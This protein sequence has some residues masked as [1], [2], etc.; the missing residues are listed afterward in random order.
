MTLYEASQKL[1]GA[2]AL[3][4]FLSR[5]SRRLVRGLLIFAVVVSALYGTL[6]GIFALPYTPMGTGLTFIFGAILGSFWLFEA[7]YNTYYFHGLNSLIGLEDRKV[8]GCSYEVA[9]IVLSDASDIAAAFLRSPVG[10]EAALRSGLTPTDIEAFIGDVRTPTASAA[11]TIPDTLIVRLE[12]LGLFLLQRD[13]AFENFIQSKGIQNEQFMGALRWVEGRMLAIKRRQRWWGKDNLSRTQ[14][15]GRE[16]AFGQTFHLDQFSKDI[17]SSTV[18]TTVTNNTAY[19]TE[20]VQEIESILARELS[21]NVLLVGEAG[22]GKMDLLMEVSRR[23]S[24][25][26]AL[27]AITGQR[28][29]VLD[30]ER[31]FTV[32]AEKD[33]I[34]GAILGLLTEA[35]EAGNTII[36]I[37]NISSFLN[38]TRAIN[39]NV[40][41]I[42]DRFLASEEVHI[43]VTDTPNNYH[44]HLEPLHGFTR[45][46]QEV[47]VDTPSVE[48]TVRVLAP[49]AEMHEAE[50]GPLFTYQSLVALATAADRYIVNGVMPDKAVQ[51]LADVNSHCMK[52]GMPFVTR[53]IVYQVVSEQTGIP[54]GPIQES[55]KELLLNLEDILHQKVVGQHQAIVAIAK[56]MRRARAGIQASDRPIGSFLF[57]G[58][59]G[60]GKTETAKALASVFFHSEEAL[61]RLDMSEFSDETS[62]DRLL[63]DTEKAGVLS[64]MLQEKP[65]CVLLLDELEKADEDVH[66]LFLQILDEGIFT[67]GRGTKVN[68]RNAIIIAT[69]NAGGQLIMQTVR[70][71]KSVGQL[72]TEI[73]N[74]IIN[75]GIFKPEL[76][77]RFDST[78]IFEPLE[79]Y[80]QGAVAQ[81]MIR[82]LTER[83]R[84]QGYKLEVT[85][86]LLKAM[87]HKGY[88]PEFGAR[89]MRRLLQ[90]LVEEK[91]A[92][93]I[94]AGSLNRG[95]TVILDVGDFAPEE[96]Q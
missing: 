49:A 62:L 58:P 27:K 46:F 48:S 35:L 38:K 18:F 1:Q 12:T 68:V 6:G 59:T 87:V 63:G 31:L 53:D 76:I 83:V 60:V 4:R 55:E 20:K 77:N 32:L 34:E 74:H 88:N 54:A 67:D 79:E 19:A 92:E 45:R 25:G 2:V 90:D 23:M 93:K 13:C 7:Y 51:L 10:G 33:D 15:L 44:T 86:E 71:R 3:D 89:P 80:E 78:I 82:D 69:S 43:I 16:L 22:V 11:I 40:P 64:S 85:D 26:E 75:T 73:I 72:N 30:T 29:I 66:D 14:S 70:Q 8:T 39:I 36:V 91:V 61:N 95:E 37:E 17:R 65:Y 96:L 5:K 52:E 9:E 41:E 84:A 47:L 21:A 94:I 24:V 28:L 42:L 57:L 50:G 56:T 81:L